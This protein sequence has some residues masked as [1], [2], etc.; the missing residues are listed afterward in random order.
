MAFTL[1]FGFLPTHLGE[2][3]MKPAIAAALISLSLFST[4]A[5]AEEPAAAV[6]ASGAAA[7]P[8]PKAYVSAFVGTTLVT[9]ASSGE[10]L[11]PTQ[12]IS[13]M[14]GGGYVINETWAVELDIGPTFVVGNGYTG[15]AVQPG[16]VITL[17]SF[18][19]VCAR[20]LATVHPTLSF[21]AIPGVGLTYTFKGG[22]A[23]FLEL[24]GVIARNA[25]GGADLSALVSLG[26]AKY[27]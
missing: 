2:T 16:V 14:V 24:D 18:F 13:P 15:L 19:Y 8:A 20:L 5:L 25:T 3:R 10:V 26:I 4:A 23:P 9:R 22:W 12:D 21:A 11:G 1:Q 27:F 17:N 7:E 6:S